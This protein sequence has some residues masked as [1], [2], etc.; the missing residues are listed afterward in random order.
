MRLSKLSPRRKKE[1][2]T[3]NETWLQSELLYE[4]G[5]LQGLDM[6]KKKMYV[7]KL[8]PDWVVYSCIKMVRKSFEI[9]VSPKGPFQSY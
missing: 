6:K 3:G 7:T 2:E 8:K 9:V 5:F 1:G 4:L